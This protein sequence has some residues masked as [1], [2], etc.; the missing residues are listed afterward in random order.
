MIS[1]ALSSLIYTLL[2]LGEFLKQS[3]ELNTCTHY[4]LLVK[5]DL[6]LSSNLLH[7]RHEMPSWDSRQGPWLRG[8]TR[9]LANALV[10]VSSKV[11]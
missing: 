3:I 9:L 1:V 11:T 4:L 6:S 7:E 5:S 2:F 10:I 8:E